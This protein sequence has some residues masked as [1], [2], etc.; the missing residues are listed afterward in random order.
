MNFIFTFYT[1]FLIGILLFVGTIIY[2][3]FCIKDRS[4][5]IL[6]SLKTG[7][8]FIV[9]IVLLWMTVPDLKAIVFKDFVEVNGSCTIDQNSGRRHSEPVV[10]IVELNESFTFRNKPELGAYG[11]A[12]VYDCT[13]KVTKDHA[14]GIAYEIYDKKT[15]KLLE[16]GK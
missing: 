3:I 14:F 15:K 2:T 11:P 7:L 13:L 5:S 10:T 9:G 16:K 8:F 12:V 4:I 1:L 6:S